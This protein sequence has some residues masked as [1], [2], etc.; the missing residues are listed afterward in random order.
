MVKAKLFSGEGFPAKYR[1]ILDQ[2][3]GY[4]VGQVLNLYKTFNLIM[5]I[6]FKKKYL[7]ISMY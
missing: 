6:P 5:C 3:T 4:I 1:V 7:L 2:Y